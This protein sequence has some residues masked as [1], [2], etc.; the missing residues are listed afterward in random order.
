[1]ITPSEARELRAEYIA[2][3]PE[4]IRQAAKLLSE[5]IKGAA[6]DGK[7]QVLASWFNT[8]KAGPTLFLKPQEIG[9]KSA[10]NILLLAEFLKAQEDP[11]DIS[12]ESNQFMVYGVKIS[13]EVATDD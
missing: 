11:F 1:M 8:E 5:K 3:R 7:C 4:V 9:L 13:W 6:A 10:S 12:I 2:R